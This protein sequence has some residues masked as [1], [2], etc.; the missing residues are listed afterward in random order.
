VLGRLAISAAVVVA[1]RLDSVPARTCPPGTHPGGGR[2]CVGPV[3][4]H[5]GGGGG[6]VTIVISVLAGILV[7]VGA[8]LVLRRQLGARPGGR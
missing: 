6:V 8:L 1:R 3:T 5:S 4:H 2:V 7:A